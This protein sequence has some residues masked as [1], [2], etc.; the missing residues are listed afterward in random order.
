MRWAYA[1][2]LGIVIIAV[3]LVV[4]F[5]LCCFGFA[6]FRRRQIMQKIGDEQL[7]KEMTK[8]L[9]L[10]K[11]YFK[12]FLLVL[13]F[14]LAVLAS[15]RPQ[16]GRNS[17]IQE[18]SGIDI[19]ITFDVSKSMLA[20]D[21]QPSRIEAAKQQ[22]VALI[23]GLHGH[24]MALVPFAG[25]A[26][27]QS[28]LTA[29]KSAFR[30]YMKGLN[31]QDM[32]VGGTNLGMAIRESISRLTG[33][34]DRGDKASRSRVILL[35]TDGEDAVNDQGADAKAAA[36]EAAKAGILIYA[37]AVGTKSGEPIPILNQDGSHAGY[38]KDR[39]GKPIYSKLNVSLLEEL[40][41]LSDPEHPNDPKVYLLED[42]TEVVSQLEKAFS[43]LQKATFE[44]TVRHRY[45]EKYFWVLIPLILILLLEMLITDQKKMVDTN[46]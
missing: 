36:E 34:E 41:R 6:H 13:S 14:I 40:A 18:Q 3:L 25:I 12:Q 31:P 24:R 38:Q 11:R 43:K 20:K 9:S 46:A 2:N 15:F 22:I 39:T 8:T 32:P 16:F 30:L 44:N 35:V 45:G 37:I 1:S 7:I 26:F 5:A 29:D 27:T 33:K 17:E 10:D 23:N 19:A 42:A 28:P 4:L 21:V